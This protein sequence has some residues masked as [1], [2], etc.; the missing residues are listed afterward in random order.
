MKVRKLLAVLERHG[1]RIVRIR[2]SHRQ[3]RHAAYPRVLTVSGNPG[4]E[5]PK[6]T[7]KAILKH[8]GIEEG[9]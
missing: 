1:W 8:A 5:V 6:G 2:G 7:L 4:A 9:R 3:L